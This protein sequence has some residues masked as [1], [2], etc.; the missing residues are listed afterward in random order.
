[1]HW[2]TLNPGVDRELYRAGQP[3]LILLLTDDQ[4]RQLEIG[5][6]DDLWRWL[7]GKD[8]EPASEFLIEYRGGELFIRRAVLRYSEPAPI[9][10]GNWRFT[11]YFAWHSPGRLP[12]ARPE[13]AVPI[14]VP[15]QIGGQKSNSWSLPNDHWRQ[16]AA[17]QLH[18]QSYG[19]PCFHA[20]AVEGILKKWFR[21]Q[22]T[23]GSDLFL[24]C[25]P[26]GLC[27]HASHLGRARK[28]N[29]LHW[30]LGALLNFW[31]WANG[32]WKDPET[33]FY[34]FIEPH[35]PLAELPSLK[36]MAVNQH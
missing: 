6:G 5:V 14:P 18:Q 9:P 10:A 29:L 12:A 36:G 7:A 1:M 32:Q 30:N 33:G 20:N 16:D 23:S 27:D 28:K 21:A 13:T 26:P 17:I 22:L 35:S 24:T 34:L 19:P 3:F 25:P 11:W 2:T 8:L 15:W 31:S 4:G